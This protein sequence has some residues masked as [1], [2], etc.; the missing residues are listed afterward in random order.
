M[1][2]TTKLISTC[3]SKKERSRLWWDTYNGNKLWE[4]NIKLRIKKQKREAYFLLY[5]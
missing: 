2:T 1:L 5:W 3:S 4:D